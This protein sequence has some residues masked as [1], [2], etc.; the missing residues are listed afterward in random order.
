VAS[1]A[2]NLTLLPM[3]FSLL[4]LVIGLAEMSAGISRN[5]ALERQASFYAS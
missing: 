1:G 5:I 4:A 2:R 3:L